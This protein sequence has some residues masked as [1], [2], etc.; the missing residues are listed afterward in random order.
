MV[1]TWSEKKHLLKVFEKVLFAEDVIIAR[2]H[3]QADFSASKETE[4]FQNR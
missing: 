1:I 2:K 3:M 4:D